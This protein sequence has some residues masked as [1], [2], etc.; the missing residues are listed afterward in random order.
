MKLLNVCVSNLDVQ[1]VDP[2][3]DWADREEARLMKTM[4]GK[5]LKEPRVSPSQRAPDSA[6]SPA[7][8]REEE[9]LLNTM[10]GK[11]RK[12][13]DGAE[14]A[15]TTK[16]YGSVDDGGAVGASDAGSASG[17]GGGVAPQREGASSDNG[18]ALIAEINVLRN[19]PS[20]YAQYIEALLPRY[21]DIPGK[22]GNP[23]KTLLMS[24]DGATAQVVQ[25]GAEAAKE[26]INVLKSTPAVHPLVCHK[27]LCKAE[28]S[29]VDDQGPIGGT[30]NVT[31]DGATLP[32]RVGTFGRPH[33]GDISESI[34]MGP[35]SPRDIV[36][37]WII[38]DGN[39]TRVHR[40]GLLDERFNAAGAGQAT[41]SK[42]RCMT[43]MV[44]CTGFDEGS[45][46][47]G[48]SSTA[49]SSVASGGAPSATTSGAGD[50][51]DSSIKGDGD[52]EEAK[53]QESEDGTGFVITTEATK[54]PKESIRLH[55]VGSSAL[56]LVCPTLAWAKQFQLP[57]AFPAS[58]VTASYDGTTTSLR[59]FIPKPGLA[60]GV[61]EEETLSEFSLRADESVPEQGSLALSVEQT[62]EA[63]TIHVN[64]SGFDCNVKL[65]RMGETVVFEAER[66]EPVEGGIKT[67]TT[68]QSFK[69]PFAR[70]K[71]A[72]SITHPVGENKVDVLIKAPSAEDHEE[73]EVDI[74]IE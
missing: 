40:K 58:S 44:L 13:L 60:G 27:G 9:R 25:D 1:D 19:D 34:A 42:Y 35:H 51:G 67:I 38:D 45:S 69:L 54:E 46:S 70:P 64:P 31:T 28:Q 48:V 32:Q 6:D 7:A 37:Q 47:G 68:K 53:L 26:A 57:F 24:E 21:K 74:P 17:G 36:V 20:S 50:G 66:Q 73:G 3:D 33:A 14:D 52:R 11:L 72:F 4:K 39:P 15:P 43:A 23:P 18:P 61:G 65:K 2:K 29:L 12:A 30:S 22:D 63:I 56:K 5:F 59:I 16:P 55:K 8:S 49:P 10:G 71:S 62:S 41:H